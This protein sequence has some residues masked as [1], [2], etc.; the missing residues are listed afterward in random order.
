MTKEIKTRKN[1][2]DVTIP[3]MMGS[4]FI[5]SGWSPLDSF[6][7]MKNEKKREILLVHSFLTSI[8]ELY[9]HH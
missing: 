8:I 5:V 2:D 1:P 3:M 9:Y 7:P 6:S 4:S